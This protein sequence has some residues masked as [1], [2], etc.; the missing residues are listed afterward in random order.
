MDKKH[1]ILLSSKGLSRL[2]NVPSS[3][4]IDIIVGS[5]TYPVDIHLACYISP[6][7]SQ[8]IL[9][10]PLLDKFHFSDI[11]EEQFKLILDLMS[12]HPIIIDDDN[13]DFLIR[14][15]Q[16]FDNRELIELCL[17][18]VNQPLKLSNVLSK[19]TRKYE[20]KIDYSSEVEFAASNLFEFEDEDLMKLE[21]PILKSL[22]SCRRLQIRNESWLF[23]FVLTLIEMHGDDYRCL[24]GYVN[25]EALSDRE[26]ID[27][28]NMIY[29]DDI[30]GVLWSALSRRLMKNVANATGRSQR[31]TKCFSILS[32]KTEYYPYQDNKSFDGVF[33]NLSK[34]YGNLC[35]NGIV[36]MSS[37]GNIS[38]PPNEIIDHN[39][40]GY[41]YSTNFPNSWVMID[42]GSQLRIKPSAYSLRSAHFMPCVV[43]HLKSWVL[44]GSSD[45]K[46]WSELDRQKN[47]QDLNGDFKFKTWQCKELDSFRYIRLRQTSKNHHNSHFLFL[48]NIELFGTLIVEEHEVQKANNLNNSSSEEEEE[49]DFV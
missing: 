34:K 38:M 26:M 39:F 18:F 43:E 49:E 35:E 28:I 31:T 41:W 22:L 37:S 30:D 9:S 13:V 6:L 12:G 42:F 27:F 3:D 33:S 19:I 40:T 4:M 29:L 24:L 36:K 14:A 17:K 20:F 23:S 10:D 15:G 8:M 7:I 47:T 45:A 44:E 11:D 25:F 16:I 48:N 2:S 1:P 21:L 32:S 5:T 46:N